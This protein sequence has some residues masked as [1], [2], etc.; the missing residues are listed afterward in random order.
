MK[1]MERTFKLTTVWTN[2]RLEKKLEIG[3]NTLQYAFSDTGIV[4]TITSNRWCFWLRNVLCCCEQC[5]QN[6]ESYPYSSTDLLLV[7]T[8]SYWS[9][10]LDPKHDI[11]GWWI[12]TDSYRTVHVFQ[13]RIIPLDNEKFIGPGTEWPPYGPD[14]NSFE[15]F[16]DWVILRIKFF[17]QAHT[18]LEDLKKVIRDEIRD[19]E[20]YVLQ[21]SQFLGQSHYVGLC[22]RRPFKKYFL[23]ISLIVRVFQ[24]MTVNCI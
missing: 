2:L 7:I 21:N 14:L 3:C 8:G 5:T 18:T 16:S 11:I 24:K 4:K 19:I 20:I 23:L 9:R 13:E 15:F 17:T 10:S 12:H 22:R 1:L 6:A